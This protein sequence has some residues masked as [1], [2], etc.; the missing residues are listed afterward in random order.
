MAYYQTEGP[1]DP[2]LITL[3]KGAFKLSFVEKPVREHDSGPSRHNGRRWLLPRIVLVLVTAWAVAAS[4]GVFRLR[5]EAAAV[6]SRW[7]PELE[8]LWAPFL[9]TERPLLVCLGTPMFVRF[10]NF[11]FFRDPKTNDWQEIDKSERIAAARN[12]LGGKDILPSYAFTGTGEASAAFLISQLLA[13]RRSDV[14]M[15]RSNILSWQ[16]VVEDNVVFLGPPKFNPQL[17]AAALTRDIVIEPEGIRNLKPQPGEP[18]FLEDHLLAGRQSEGETHA[19]ISRTPGPTGVGEF[20]IIAGN[21]SA[22]TFGAA[23]WLTQ[24]WRARELARHLRTASG[25][26]PRYFQVVIKVA[27]KQG[28]PVQ[29]SYVFHHALDAPGQQPAARR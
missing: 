17:Q 21:A 23:E 2:V 11:G 9:A 25:E 7:T 26:V 3:P 27:F 4:I 1:D 19:L 5:R 8:S 14:L 10:P 16:Q 20:L 15:T 13:T 22:D 28:I 18:V 6:S 12:A 24:P 29:S